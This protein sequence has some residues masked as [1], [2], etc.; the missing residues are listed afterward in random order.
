MQGL[1]AIQ[2][3]FSHMFTQVD[4]PGFRVTEHVADAN[5]AMLVWEF[6]FQFKGKPQPH[7]LR[8]TSHLKFDADGKVRYHR[9]YNR[10][11]FHI[12]KSKFLNKSIF[13]F[14]RSKFCVFFYFRSNNFIIF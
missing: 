3:I 12:R 13:L 5:G 11:I 2:R 10:P 7:V 1:A 6:H 4:R 9:D 14:L 8:G